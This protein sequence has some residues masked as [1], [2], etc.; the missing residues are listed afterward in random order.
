MATPSLIFEHLLHAAR[1]SIDETAGIMITIENFRKRKAFFQQAKPFTLHC[2]LLFVVMF[3]SYAGGMIFYYLEHDVEVQMA[4]DDKAMRARC[5]HEVF[6]N[7][8]ALSYKNYKPTNATITQIT[9]CFHVDIDPRNQWSQLTAVFYSF[10]IATTLGYNRLQ[11]IT[12]EGRMF[13]LIYGICGIPIT[14]IIIANVG[15]YLHQFASSFRKNIEARRKRRRPSKANITDDDIPDQSI[16]ATSLAL[17][18]V[19]LLYVAFGAFV[20]PLLNGE[21]DFVNGLYY[22]FIT[23]TAIDF[24]HIVPNELKYWPVTFLYICFGLGIT[25]IAIDVGAQYMKKLHNLGQKM[26]NVAQTKIWFGGKT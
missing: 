1:A 18:G 6:D 19:F 22:N 23:L 13:C 25:T 9:Q 14:M 4:I 5:V 16:E 20:L 7:A 8:T 15:Q 12:L 24:G 11:P 3:Y 10:G 26:K 21:L 2:S 17:V